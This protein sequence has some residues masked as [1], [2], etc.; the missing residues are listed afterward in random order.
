MYCTVMHTYIPRIH[1]V[2]Y[3]I[4]NIHYT[5]FKDSLSRDKLCMS[6]FVDRDTTSYVIHLNSI[7]HLTKKRILLY[8]TR[9]RQ[10][11]RCGSKETS[12][13]KNRDG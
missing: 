3:T 5:F 9:S 12:S 13:E 1:N 7:F 8:C 4:Y 6:M 2:H 10:G 11:F